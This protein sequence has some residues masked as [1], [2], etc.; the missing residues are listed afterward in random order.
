MCI[1]DRLISVGP[2]MF[3]MPCSHCRQDGHNK[4]TCQVRIREELDRINEMIDHLVKALDIAELQRSAVIKELKAV[5]MSSG[6]E[7]SEVDG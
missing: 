4:T 1:R 7:S 5:R 2:T 6:P 3:T